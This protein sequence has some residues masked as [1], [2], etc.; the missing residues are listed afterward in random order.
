MDEPVVHIKQEGQSPEGGKLTRLIKRELVDAPAEQEG[1]DDQVDEREYPESHGHDSGQDE[2]MA[3]DLS[4]APD[5]MTPEDQM[6]A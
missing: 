1:E 2:D 6:E 5:I 4:M 3:E